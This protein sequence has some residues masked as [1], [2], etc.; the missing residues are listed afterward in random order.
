METTPVF[1][2]AALKSQLGLVPI[3]S[4]EIQ[5]NNMSFNDANGEAVSISTYQNNNL[6]RS[7]FNLSFNKKSE[8]RSSKM[9]AKS[10]LQLDKLGFLSPMPKDSTNC[11]Q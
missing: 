1:K 9:A 3:E 7:Q 2:S 11:K 10:S 6:K 5:V 8:V 4:P